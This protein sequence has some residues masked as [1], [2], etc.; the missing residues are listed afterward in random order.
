MCSAFGGVKEIVLPIAQFMPCRVII[1]LSFFFFDEYRAQVTKTLKE[2]FT[3]TFK[4]CQHLLT[5][6]LFQNR[7]QN[8]D[9][10]QLKV[11]NFNVLRARKGVLNTGF[12]WQVF[13]KT[14]LLLS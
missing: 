14:I 1:L 6:K 10:F 8:R 3:R 2:K 11:Y 13:L 9:T 12:K 5:L 4:F 7:F